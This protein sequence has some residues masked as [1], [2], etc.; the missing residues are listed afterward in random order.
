MYSFD[1]KFHYY[2]VSIKSSED[3][4]YLVYAF[5]SSYFP[6]VFRKY[7]SYMTI[8]LYRQPATQ[9]Y[10]VSNIRCYDIN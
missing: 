1:Y 4:S 6:L 2:N 5:I 7:F 8:Y 9:D 10:V 3:L